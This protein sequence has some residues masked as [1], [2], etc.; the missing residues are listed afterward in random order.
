MNENDKKSYLT[1]WV[2]NFEV[3]DYLDALSE[4]TKAKNIY[5]FRQ[6]GYDHPQAM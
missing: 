4:R 6:V 2:A 1:D 5:F 3:A